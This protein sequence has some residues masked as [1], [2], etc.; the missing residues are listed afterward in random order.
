MNKYMMKL[1][2]AVLGMFL[3]ACGQPEIN[4]QTTFNSSIAEAITRV[5]SKS[6]FEDKLG[7]W[8]YSTYD[9]EQFMKIGVPGDNVSSETRNYDLLSDPRNEIRLDRI[10][11][12]SD[13]TIS[14]GHTYRIPVG[15]NCIRR[16]NAIDFARDDYA[17]LV[18][19]RD[20]IL[21]TIDRT[22][23]QRVNMIPVEIDFLRCGPIPQNNNGVIEVQIRIRNHQT[24]IEVPMAFSKPFMV[25]R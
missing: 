25:R 24:G 22:T 16:L 13:S 4:I 20:N 9:Q 14:L 11:Y 12:P 8:I 21:T 18:A 2:A 5:Y 23:G 7:Y 3:M 1:T 6:S 15:Q 10:S 17:R 19:A